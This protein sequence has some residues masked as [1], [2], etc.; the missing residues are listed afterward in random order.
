MTTPGTF[1]DVVELL[2]PELRRRGL[3]ARPG[4]RK[5]G[6]TAREKVYGE[7]QSKM[8]DD[9]NGSGYKYNVYKEDLPF[10]KKAKS[11][12]ERDAK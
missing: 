11:E 8:R 4:E 2:I 9:H 5:D 6:L 3:Y 10:Q 12:K 1:E 7:G